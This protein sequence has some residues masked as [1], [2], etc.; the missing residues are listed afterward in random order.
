MLKV[1]HL[2]N[3]CLLIDIQESINKHQL[4]VTKNIN[5]DVLSI[6]NTTYCDFYI[7]HRF[8]NE[9]CGNDV[10]FINLYKPGDL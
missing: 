6:E 7:K 5:I 2:Y 4:E 1:E 9:L 10:N 8:P 3:N